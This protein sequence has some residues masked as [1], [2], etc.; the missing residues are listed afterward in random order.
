ML[1]VILRLKRVVLFIFQIKFKQHI[2]LV[3]K[4][5]LTNFRTQLKGSWLVCVGIKK[6]FSYNR[7]ALKKLWTLLGPVFLGFLRAAGRCLA[8]GSTRRVW[9][10]S[11]GLDTT[12]YG[13][14]EYV[15]DVQP[16]RS[17]LVPNGLA[18]RSRALVHPARLDLVL[19]KIHMAAA[20]FLRRVIL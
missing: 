4:I 6:G 10:E 9:P 19:F 5:R 2:L 16:G 18:P 11:R 12:N 14:Q 7:N 8:L 1:L 15:E 3:I 20:A 13:R 17:V